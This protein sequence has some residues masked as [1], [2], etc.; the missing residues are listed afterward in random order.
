MHN[1]LLFASCYIHEEL[2]G[3][4]A[5]LR[6][7]RSIAMQEFSTRVLQ[8]ADVDRKLSYLV[9]LDPWP[10]ARLSELDEMFGRAYMSQLTQLN[11]RCQ[12]AMLSDFILGQVAGAEWRLHAAT[13][14]YDAVAA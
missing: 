14:E 8:L 5:Q 9:Q 10:L 1:G 12:M 7:F 6:K 3:G 4:G 2:G 11:K 13:R